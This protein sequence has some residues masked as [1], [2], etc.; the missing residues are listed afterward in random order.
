MFHV[1]PDAYATYLSAR[2]AADALRIPCGWILDGGT[3]Y[4]GVL[5]EI[6]V[7]QLE[8]PPPPPP[9][10]TPQGPPPM[11]GPKVRLD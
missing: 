11:P 9:P 3:G 7:N 1:R 4:D 10:T 2:D 6:E 8:L 5:N